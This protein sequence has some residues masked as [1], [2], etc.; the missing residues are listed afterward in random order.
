MRYLV[1]VPLLSLLLLLVPTAPAAGGLGVFGSWWDGDLLDQGFG[2]GVKMEVPVIP[3]PLF[4]IEGRASYL[5]FSEGG[6]TVGAIPLE[7][8]GYVDFNLFYAGAGI[9][10]Y[11]F[12]KN[13]EDRVG[14]LG[15]A[16]AK[17]SLAG[18]GVFGEVLYRVIDSQPFD[19]FGAN[20][21]V[22]L[23]L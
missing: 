9:G 8:V 6:E 10:W 15:L 4:G 20:V 11:V 1:L 22:T 17:L 23:G 16:G 21:G 3:T 7:A 5:A 2:G 14:V 19:G 13:I 12:N 18:F